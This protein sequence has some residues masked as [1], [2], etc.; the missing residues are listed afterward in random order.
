MSRVSALALGATL[1]MP[2][3]RADLADA[4]HGAKRVP[5]L[6][7]ARLC[8]DNALLERDLPVALTWAF[9]IPSFRANAKFW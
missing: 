7:S 3:T 4:L 2:C 9:G 1:Y 5:G 8:L 6:R